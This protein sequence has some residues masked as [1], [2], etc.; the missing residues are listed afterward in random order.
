MFH[1]KF[2]VQ[3]NS[4]VAACP[5]GTCR[6]TQSGQ[7]WNICRAML[8][9]MLMSSLLRARLRPGTVKNLYN[10]CKIGL[11]ALCCLWIYG[12]VAAFCFSLR[13]R[14]GWN[15]PQLP[16][17][18]GKSGCRKNACAPAV[19]KSAL[20][21]SGRPIPPEPLPMNRFPEC[22]CRASPNSKYLIDNALKIDSAHPFLCSLGLAGPPWV[23]IEVLSAGAIVQVR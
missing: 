5:F 14:A 6:R 4:F 23:Q 15:C 22:D 2:Y 19:R 21:G 9:N 16:W 17:S 3:R 7:T 18:G 11:Q 20:E 13:G 8:V 10:R 1:I 12:I